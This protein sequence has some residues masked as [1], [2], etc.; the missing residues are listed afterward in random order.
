MSSACTFCNTFGTEV[1]NKLEKKYFAFINKY[2]IFN[3][4]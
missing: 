4:K 2:V 1:V 3:N